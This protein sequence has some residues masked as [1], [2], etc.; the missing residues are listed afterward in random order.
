ML[1]QHFYTHVIKQKSANLMVYYGSKLLL[2]SANK[3]V[4]VSEKGICFVI[5]SFLILKN[6]FHSQYSHMEYTLFGSKIEPQR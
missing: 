4:E 1:V 2:V 5:V 6:V 3:L